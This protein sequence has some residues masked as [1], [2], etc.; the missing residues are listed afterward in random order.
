MKKL[1]YIPFLTSL[2]MILCSCSSFQPTMR[3]DEALAHVE[4]NIVY[5]N[6]EFMEEKDLR[7]PHGFNEENLGANT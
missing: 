3:V 7:L 4:N 1:F 5:H 6:R 2:M